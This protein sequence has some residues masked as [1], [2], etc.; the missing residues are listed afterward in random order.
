[1]ILRVHLCA[2][3]V[4]KKWFVSTLLAFVTRD[5]LAVHKLCPGLDQSYQFVQ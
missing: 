5:I 2:T 4:K 1:M 3:V